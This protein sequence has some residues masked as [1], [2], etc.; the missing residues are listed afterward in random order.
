MPKKELPTIGKRLTAA[1]EARAISLAELSRATYEKAWGDYISVSYGAIYAIENEKSRN[2]GILV[3]KS[4]AR[5]LGIKVSE[6]IGE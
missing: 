2:P 4:L 3:L 1:R 6:L 5:A